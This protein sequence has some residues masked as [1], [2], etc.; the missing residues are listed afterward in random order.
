MNLLHNW[1][2]AD[3]KIQAK[4]KACKHTCIK[5]GFY[6]SGEKRDICKDCGQ[7]FM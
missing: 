4:R 7:V 3:Q 6:P 2:K 1:I 5:K